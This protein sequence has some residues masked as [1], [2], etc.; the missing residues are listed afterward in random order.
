MENRRSMPK[1]SLPLSGGC[2]C[3]GV[4]YAITAV[5]LTLY[6]CHCTECQRQSSSAFGMSMLVA[7]SA[8]AVDWARLGIFVRG[9]AAGG[10][11]I[12][13]LFCPDCGTRLF[14]ES[15]QENEVVSVKAGSLDNTRWLRPVGHLWTRRAQPW[16]RIPPDDLAYPGEPPSFDGLYRRWET[17]ADEIF[18]DGKPAH[19]PE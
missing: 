12:R 9:T 16:V 14:H 15:T 7:R 1:A 13:C 8:L 10:R 18:A 6:L 19:A 5:P 17:V 11:E 2:Q 4:R 3:G